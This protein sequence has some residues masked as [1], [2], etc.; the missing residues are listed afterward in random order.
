MTK[1]NTH[2]MVQI[3][4]IGALYTVLTLAVA[5]LSFGAVQFRVSEAL[6]LLPLFSSVG[7]WGVTF[8]CFFSNLLGFLLGTNPLGVVDAFV[9]TTATLSAAVMTWLIGRCV[10]SKNER[11]CRM[12]RM[13][14]GP[15]P[16]V[17]M[18]ALLVGLELA[19]VFGGEPGQSF[20]Y[21][22]AFNALSVALGEAIVCYTLGLMLCGVL[23][24][25]D[26]YKK[27]LL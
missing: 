19:V 7:I 20:G 6:V 23:G 4:L 3:A 16:A 26:L 22:F 8:G 24:R 27:L 5:P 21:I 11:H 12:V 9:G 10:F 15:V 1:A 14:L 2:R 18:N 25:N 13:L 17:V